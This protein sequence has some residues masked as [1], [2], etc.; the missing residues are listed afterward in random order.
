[1]PPVATGDANGHTGTERATPTQRL[2]RAWRE[3]RRGPV[4]GRV[5]ELLFGRP[6]EPDAVDPA[7]LDILDLLAIRDGRRMS[8][9]AA[10]LRV[11]P[12]TV[13][14]TMHRMEAAGLA[15]RAA[16]EADGRV[17]TAHLTDEGRRLHDVVA[18]RR[19]AIVEAGLRD[20]TPAEQKQLVD[21]LERFLAAVGRNL[22][23]AADAAP[24]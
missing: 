12:S 22:T 7:H 21:L 20:L 18:A 11:D 15:K 4:T 14:R 2:S 1:M 9:L 6:G 13:T 5:V 24:G 17:V 23:T 10:E 8:D 3:M 16:A 19:Q